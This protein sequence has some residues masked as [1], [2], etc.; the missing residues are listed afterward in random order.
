MVNVNHPL[1]R[2]PIP[3]V[4]L[5]LALFYLYIYLIIKEFTYI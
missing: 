4:H 2:M 3:A 5:Y 1:T